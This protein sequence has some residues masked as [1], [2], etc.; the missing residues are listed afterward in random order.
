[1]IMFLSLFCKIGSIIFLKN[2]E[3]PA[4][5]GMTLL[6]NSVITMSFLRMVLPEGY[7]QSKYLQGQESKSHIFQQP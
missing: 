7:L 2:N 3:I 6:S 5:A 4:Y 1:M